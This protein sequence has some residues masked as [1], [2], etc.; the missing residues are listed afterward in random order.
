MKV[1]KTNTT[2]K[3]FEDFIEEYLINSHAYRARSP[4]EH[5]DKKLAMDTGLVFEFINTTQAE[6]WSKLVE[7]YGTEENAR[8]GFLVRLDREIERVG[9]LEILRKGVV[10]RGVLIKLAFFPPETSLNPE[11]VALAEAN[12]FSVVR[13][14]KYS[15]RNENSIDLVIFL[16]GLPI[17][18]AELKNQLTGQNVKNSVR[19]YITDRDEKEKLLSFKRA[20]THFAV[21]T[22]LVYMATE[23]KGPAT[24]FLPFNKGENNSAGNPVNPNGYKTAYLWEEVWSKESILELVGRFLT[25]TV[26]EKV[27]K[28]RK[29]TR[30]EVLVFPRYHQRDAVRRLLADAKLHG[31]GQNYLIQ[32]SAGSGKSMTIAWSAHQL[33]ELH[34]DKD[35]KVFD[36]VIV[37]TD[38]RVLDQQLSATV[39]QFSQVR[40]VVVDIDGTSQQLKEAL[41]SGAKIITTTLQKFPVIVDSLDKIAGSKFAVLID[42]AHSSQS[43]ESSKSLKQALSVNS[44]EEAE[45]EDEDTRIESIEDRIIKDMRSRR[46]KTDHISFLAFTATPKQKT[47]ELFGVKGEDGKFR[48]FSLYSMKQAIEEGFILDVLQNYTPYKVYFGLLKK[49]IEDPEVSKKEAQKLLIRYVEKHEHAINEK[50]KIMVEHFAAHIAPLLGGRAKAM[51]VTRS[52]LHA[53]RFKLA[54]DAYLKDQGY[55]YKAMVAFSGTV[56]DGNEDYTEARMNGVPEKQTKEVFAQDENRIMIVAEKFQTGFDEPLLSVMYVDKK[57]SGVNAVQTLSRLNR[58]SRGKESVFVLDFVNDADDIRKSFEPY[59]TTTILSGETDVS[60]VYELASDVENFKLFADYEVAGYVEN[61]YKGAK[62]DVLNQALDEVVGRFSKIPEDEQDDFKQKLS[63]YVRKYAFISQIITFA[64]SNLEKLYIF[65]KHLHKKLPKKDIDLPT[66]ILEAVDMEAYKIVRKKTRQ[67]ALGDGEELEPIKIAESGL[68]YD[69]KDL[70]SNIVKSINEKFGAELTDSD[71]GILQGLTSRLRDNKELQG[72]V[73]ENNPE[74]AKIKFDSLFQD[75]LMNIL[76]EH[77]D[78]YK[79]LDNDREL[80]KYVNQKIFELIVKEVKA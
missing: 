3:G 51:I 13:Q 11:A 65:L 41:E 73:K 15:E 66:D 2:E 31:A 77:F 62:P 32:H 44:L 25:L 71:R 21:D 47:L 12:I 67:I 74:S 63:E 28:E 7:A 69:D 37:V 75:E 34:N 6:S 49:A 19:Q 36:S 57:L 20:L 29:K 38:R 72:T 26:E 55:A 48:P 33:S 76:N 70:L 16:N 64:D 10:D 53:V 61:L 30:K 4:R 58:S 8:E 42:E 50:T 1:I 79:K 46:A 43:G 22:D 45:S 17:F 23:L 52:R 5:Y 78:L 80:K 60:L 24:F 56:S 40:G 54:V 35:E 18:T 14:L 59:Y 68:M 27:D 9:V 39:D